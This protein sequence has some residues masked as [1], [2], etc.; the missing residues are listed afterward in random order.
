M[1]R[2]GM[3]VDG[4]Y[5]RAAGFLHIRQRLDAISAPAAGQL[6]ERVEHSDFE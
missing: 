2:P 3:C 4:T 1:N 5:A 6:S